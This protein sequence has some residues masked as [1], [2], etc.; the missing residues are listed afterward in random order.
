[1]R[2]KKRKRR[3]KRKPSKRKKRPELSPKA[4][5]MRWNERKSQLSRRRK[6]K[7][8]RIHRKRRISLSTWARLFSI[9]RTKRKVISTDRSEFLYSFYKVFD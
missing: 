9:P 8:T 5:G 2:K 6:K 1:M 7:S 4:S 3:K